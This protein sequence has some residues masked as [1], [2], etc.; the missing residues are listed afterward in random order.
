MTS[1][2]QDPTSSLAAIEDL[3]VSFI[4]QELAGDPDLDIDRD[5]NLLMSGLVDSV[6]ILRLIAHV[7][8]RLEV[9]VPP[10]DLVPGNFR[11]VRV[12]AGYLQGRTRV[13]EQ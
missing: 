2:V 13:S 4:Q 7:S 10:Q 9:T 11:T 3:I 1:I 5:E 8:D 12:M 6:G